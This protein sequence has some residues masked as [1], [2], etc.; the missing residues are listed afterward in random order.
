MP[1]EYWFDFSCPYAYIGSTQIERI[2]ERAHTSVSWRPMLLGGVFNAIGEPATMAPAKMAHNARDM[3]RWADRRGVPLE[4]PPGHPIRTVRA[5]RALL[6]LPESMWPAAIHSLYRAYWVDGGGIDRADVIERA[7]ERAGVTGDALARARTANDDPAIKEQ[8]R[9][10][11]EEAVARGAFGAPTIFADDQMF[12]GQDR[13]GMVGAAL[14]GW[15][16][17]GANQSD[18][19]WSATGLDDDDAFD[20]RGSAIDFWYDISSPFSYLAATQIERIAERAG[21]AL[22]WRPMLLGGLFK[23]LGGPNV[24]LL[25][26]SNSKRAYLGRELGYWASYWNVPFRFTPT[27]P[28]RTITAQR[29]LLAVGDRIG[30]LTLAI[31]RAAWIDGVNVGDDAALSQVIAAAGFD[32]PA[33]MSK[34]QDPAI[35]QQLIANTSEAAAA[36]VFGAPTCIVDNGS[37]KFLFWGQDRLELVDR[38]ARGWAPARG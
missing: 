12:F 13:L 22:R 1:L 11:T 38:C 5:L 30:P 2:A 6:S 10:R 31:Y 33:V 19:S 20:R 4:M 35:K 21:A 24:P 9:V 17:G 7:L 25:S 15:R 36:G 26:F 18:A 29:A 28:L 3:T 34:T 27:F 23:D 8:L 37:G 16:P 32:A 14:R